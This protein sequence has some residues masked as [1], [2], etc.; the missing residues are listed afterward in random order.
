MRRLRRCS[1]RV[2]L[3]IGVMQR[4]GARHALCGT[5]LHHLV[6]NFY[7]V[8]A[9]MR[10]QSL[11][12]RLGMLRKLNT[13]HGCLLH[14]LWP[15]LVV[16]RTHNLTNPV[17]HIRFA[18]AGKE[19]AQRDELSHD[20][21]HCEHVYRCVVVPCSKQHFWRAVPARGDIFCVGR[22][23]ANLASETEVRDFRDVLGDENVFGFHVAVEVSVL[24]HVI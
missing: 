14:A 1:G 18:A 4:I 19:R 15:Y 2:P 10:H 13:P 24:M 20:A 9:G 3:E 22:L 21:A 7:C 16:G 11:Q 23:R 6:H 8:G 12:G 17:N 5:P